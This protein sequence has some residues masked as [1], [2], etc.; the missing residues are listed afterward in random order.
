[1]EKK[2]DEGVDLVTGLFALL[3]KH[4]KLSTDNLLALL[5]LLTL[6]SIVNLIKPVT[7]QLPAAGQGQPLNLDNTLMDTLTGLLHNKGPG[8]LN[9]GDLAGMLAKNPNAIA[10]LM[11]MLSMIKEQKVTP[12]NEEAGKKI[13]HD[14]TH[15]ITIKDKS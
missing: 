14:D 3:E 8:G 1:M 13:A 15:N 9:P 6:L 10:A 5:S 12:K 2:K 4:P 11:N 7:I